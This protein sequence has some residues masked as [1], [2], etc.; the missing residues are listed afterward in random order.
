MP[1]DAGSKTDGRE[2]PVPGT[3]GQKLSIVRIPLNIV[4]VQLL[5]NLCCKLVS[6]LL[7]VLFFF[8]LNVLRCWGLGRF[9]FLIDSC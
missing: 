3:L 8:P 4:K 7:K 9:S 1:S 6:S 2:P 5:I